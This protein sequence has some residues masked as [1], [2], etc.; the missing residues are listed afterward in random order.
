MLAAE[1][2][3]AILGAIHQH[4]RVTVADL[5]E[6]F[7]VSANTIRRDLR[8]LDQSRLL[9]VVHGGALAV[10]TVD[11]EIPFP[12]RQTSDIDEKM[13]IGQ[14]AAELVSESQCIILDAGTTT[15][16]VARALRSHQDLT[17]V[18]NA[19]NI[20]QE[21]ADCPGIMTMVSGGVVRGKSNCLVGPLAEQTISQWHVDTAFISAGGVDLEA[22]LTNPNPFEAPIKQAMI[23]AARQVIL[24][25]TSE[26]FGR[27]SLAPFAPLAAV[28]TI[29]TDS[30]L[31]DE[32]ALRLRNMGIELVIAGGHDDA[33]LAA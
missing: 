14:R 24:V 1:R 25:A 17:V 15:H 7:G 8:T 3:R 6:R 28:H 27:R 2:Q 4:G 11:A 23:A 26:K 10:A 13:L 12:N 31:A 29:V 18:T 5:R 32:T 30:R 21:L 22:G 16:E 9:T 19:L 33:G 20:A